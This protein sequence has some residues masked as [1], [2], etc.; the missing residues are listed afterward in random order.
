MTV[1]QEAA[2]KIHRVHYLLRPTSCRRPFGLSILGRGGRGLRDRGGHPP[3][4]EP[5]RLWLPF[6]NILK[7]VRYLGVD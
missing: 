3:D 6:K 2:E 4:V 5:H 7:S 1:K